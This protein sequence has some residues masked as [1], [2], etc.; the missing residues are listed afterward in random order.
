MKD[1]EPQRNGSFSDADLAAECTEKHDA[2]L[3]N[4]PALA[5]EGLTQA[6]LTAFQQQIKAFQALPTDENMLYAIGTNTGKRDVALEAART[7]LRHAANPIDRAYGDRS[8]EYRSLAVGN[9]SRKTV[10]QVLQTLLTVPTVG[11]AFV[12]DPKAVAEGFSEARLTALAPLY[13][14]L[15]EWESKM[16]AAET[17]RTT[18]TRTRV[19]AYNA[20]NTLCSNYCARG[21]DHFVEKDQQRAQLFVRNPASEDGSSTTPNEPPNA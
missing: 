10:P 12:N 20:L 13:T 17:A 2:L 16:H 18:A 19:L 9:I 3:A 6:M 1:P 4:L 11:A 8:P 7:G 15:F 21:Y 14:A 5:A